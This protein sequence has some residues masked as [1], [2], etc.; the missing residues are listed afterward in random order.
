M[1]DI[2]AFE[3]LTV[4]FKSEW[5]DKKD[6]V[7]IKKTLVAFANTSGGDLYIGVDDSG[8]VVG[9]PNVGEIEEKLASVMRDCISPSIAPFVETE[10]LS[11]DGKTVL[12]VHVARGTDRPY[13]LD[14]KTASGVYIRIGNTS[15]PASLD[16]IANM[17]ESRRKTPYE[18][19]VSVEQGLTFDYCAAYCRKRGFAFDPKINRGYGFWDSERGAYT[20]LAFLLSDQCDC[21]EVLASYADS[22]RLAILENR[23]V[24]GPVLKLLEEAR[25]FIDKTNYAW[26]EKQKAGEALRVDHYLIEP[27]VIQEA[28]VNMI[29]HRDYSKTASNMIRITPDKVDIF[30]IGGLAEGLSKADVINEMVTDCRNRKLAFFLHALRLM[31]SLGS[32]FYYIRNFY[33]GRSLEDLVRISET[34][35]S[36]YLPR[37]R[38]EAFVADPSHRA[39]MNY[40]SSRQDAGRTEIQALLGVSQSTMSNLLRAMI[41]KELIEKIGAGRSTRYRIRNS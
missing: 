11:A 39:V 28:L 26:L 38:K 2:P 7:P 40:L 9:L 6:G 1:R 15:S 24:T 23:R 10:R 35:F 25:A 20:N 33:K 17:I 12:C 13:C 21:S 32:G 18:S 16:D 37:P 34:S 5:N 14:P 19:R 3:S 31:E 29:A 30:T 41:E 4:E 22:E 27:R 8:E 36:I